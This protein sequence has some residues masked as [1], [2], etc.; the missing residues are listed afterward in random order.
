VTATIGK[1]N[2]DIQ[3]LN[4]N[5]V[6]LFEL[7]YFFD[8]TVVYEVFPVEGIDRSFLTLRPIFCQSIFWT[9]DKIQFWH[10]VKNFTS[11]SSSPPQPINFYLK[12]RLDVTIDYNNK[13]YY[14]YHNGDFIKIK[15]VN[16]ITTL[17]MYDREAENRDNNGFNSNI[18][19]IFNRGLINK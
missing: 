1:A 11:S 7:N 19:L 9:D 6:E 5:K 16:S 17:T 4:T 18:K 3:I 8:D 14:S 12:Q 2:D 13:V 10:I 15:F